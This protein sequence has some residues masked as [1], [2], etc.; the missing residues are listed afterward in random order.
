M[1]YAPSKGFRSYPEFG[2]LT[3]LP[4][5]LGYPLCTIANTAGTPEP[6][7]LR[8]ILGYWAD[9]SP[10]EEKEGTLASA[11]EWARIIKGL[12]FISSALDSPS[13]ERKQ[14]RQD[15]KKA[16]NRI[17]TM[18]NLRAKHLM[19]KHPG[20]DL[21]EAMDLAEEQFAANIQHTEQK[22]KAHHF[23]T[24][25]YDAHNLVYLMQDNRKVKTIRKGL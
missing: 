16:K 24:D 3:E 11:R 6:D 22:G 4:R 9:G 15:Q 21:L 7:G 1:S 19:K 12:R 2:I 23:T 17:R 8:T 10:I 25:G 5:E 18:V 13:E 20:L 14:S